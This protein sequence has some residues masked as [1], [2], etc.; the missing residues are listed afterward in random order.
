MLTKEYLEHLFEYDREK[1]VLI[2]KNPLG[3]NTKRFIGKQAGCV[4]SDGY[5]RVTISFKLYM[6]HQLIWIIEKNNSFNV[7]DHIDGNKLNNKIQNLRSV[8]VRQNSQNKYTHRNGK[9]VGSH[10][11]NTKKAWVSQI[12]INR[13]CAFSSSK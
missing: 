12:T 3:K 2:W 11:C 9:L 8:T 5:L 13:P 4:N 7:I 1:G 10:F 6:V